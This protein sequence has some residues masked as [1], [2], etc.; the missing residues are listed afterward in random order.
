MKY[1]LLVKQCRHPQCTEKYCRG[2][3]Q[4]TVDLNGEGLIPKNS[5]KVQK[6]MLIPRSQA[7]VKGRLKSPIF[8][9]NRKMISKSMDNFW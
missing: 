1:P 6:T 3:Y 5:L 9:V 8:Q 7:V 2:K 4:C